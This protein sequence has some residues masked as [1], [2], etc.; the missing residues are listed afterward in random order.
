MGQSDPTRH[1]RVFKSEKDKKEKEKRDK[2]FNHKK[3]Q[4]PDVTKMKPARR[5]SSSEEPLAKIPKK[6]HTNRES[7]TDH[8]AEITQLKEKIASMQRT[9]TSKN[10]ELVAKQGEITAMKAKLFN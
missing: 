4:R 7:D 2:Y 3:P 10:N 9:I 8:H 5:S 1:S 6:G